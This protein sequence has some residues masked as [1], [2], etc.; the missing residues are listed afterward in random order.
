MSVR[1]AALSACVSLFALG[2][3]AAPIILNDVVDV[4]ATNGVNPYGSYSSSTFADQLRGGKYWGD[5]V[6]TNFDTSKIEVSSSGT[7]A[8]FKF[9]TKFD[10]DE[11]LTHYADIF[12]DTIDPDH[13]GSFD[14]GI[15]LGMQT[16][17]GGAATAGLY[18]LAPANS[19]KTSQDVWS[20][21]TSYVYGGWYSFHSDPGAPFYKSPTVVTGNAT[22]LTDW[23]LLSSVTDLGG[24]NYVLNVD[25]TAPNAAAFNSIFTAF[26]V[27]WGT[28]DCSN[29]AIW[30]EVALPSVPEPATFALF[31]LGLF[32]LAVARRRREPVS[33]TVRQ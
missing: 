6:G 19:F 8:S 27:F 23:S 18:S 17:N 33:A 16:G 29:D 14:F 11:G 32:G 26:D 7:T 12:I 15:S 25:I 24:G 3:Q 20:G 1:F 10:G 2:A 5:A 21:R 9:F 13:P 22:R 28:G 4:A 31:G 30:G